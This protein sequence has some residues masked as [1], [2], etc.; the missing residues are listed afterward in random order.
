[1]RAAAFAAV[2]FAVSTTA[3]DEGDNFSNN[4]FSDLAP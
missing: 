1:M 4:L 3:A 2:F